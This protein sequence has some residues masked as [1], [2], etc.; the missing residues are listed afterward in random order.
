MYSNVKITDPWVITTYTT[1]ELEEDRQ[2]QMSTTEAEV[3]GV[4][5]SLMGLI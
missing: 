1:N 5:C 3:I 2:V 4:N